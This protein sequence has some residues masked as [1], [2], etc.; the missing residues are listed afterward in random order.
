MLIHSWQ[1]LLVFDTI[2]RHLPVL[3]RA[4]LDPHL[5]EFATFFF[6]E[7]L[8]LIELI[9]FRDSNVRIQV[10]KQM[11]LPSGKLT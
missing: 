5:R 4:T 9:E 2:F 1:C 7:H 6:V 8:G 10:N 11:Q 3:F